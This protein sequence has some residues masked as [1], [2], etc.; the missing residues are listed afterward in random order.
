VIGRSGLVHAEWDGLRLR[1]TSAELID[2]P[3]PASS[4]IRALEGCEVIV[5][6]GILTADLRAAVMVTD[7]PDSL[8]RRTIDTLAFAW[9]IRGE[10]FPIGCSLSA[11]TAAN[12]DGKR[13]KPRFRG[14][15]PGLRTGTDPSPKRGDHDPRDD[16]RLVAE[17]WERWIAT[18]QLSWGAGEPS[19]TAFE[20]DTREGSP[21]GTATL[22]SEQIGELTRYRPHAEAAQWRSTYRRGVPINPA[23]ADLLAN[24]S[25]ADLPAPAAI[26]AL[27][28]H[29]Q[30]AGMI[31]AGL[32]LTD[33]DLYTACQ[34]LGAK[35]NL[36]VRERIAIGGSITKP[37]REP[38]AWA[39]WQVT[40]PEWAARPWTTADKR[41]IRSRL[42][43]IVM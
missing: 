16:A 32:A 35:Q 17:L 37:L 14:S 42:E 1:E 41:R 18:R 23:S 10:R 8:L 7:V 38:L 29:L 30:N 36:C 6:H 24:L 22:G 28:E 26:R 11:L 15:A 19:W 2:G 4:L 13:P 27:A 40:H 43:A 20:G 9:R 12:L 31:P 21:G 34:Y 3:H 39:L 33:E 25:A 5:G